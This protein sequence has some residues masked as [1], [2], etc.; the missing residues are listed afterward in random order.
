M[1]DV[2]YPW[3]RKWGQF[4]RKRQLEILDLIARA[5]AEAAP[6]NAIDRDRNGHWRT[7]ADIKDFETRKALGLSAPPPAAGG[8]QQVVRV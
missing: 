1:T 6:A 7:T 8:T 4:T 2:Y 3:I 5:R